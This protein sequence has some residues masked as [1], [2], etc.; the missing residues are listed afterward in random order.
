MSL[1]R[2]K[3]LKVRIKEYL[4]QTIKKK[5]LTTIII[6]STTKTTIRILFISNNKIVTLNKW[7]NNKINNYYGILFKKK[8]TK[9]KIKTKHLIDKLYH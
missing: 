3:L 8:K 5:L 6:A 9:T 4:T 7:F 1:T 2:K